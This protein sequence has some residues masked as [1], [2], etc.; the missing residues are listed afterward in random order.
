MVKIPIIQDA[1]TDQNKS[2]FKLDRLGLFATDDQYNFSKLNL[3]ANEKEA[4]DN[5]FD[6]CLINGMEPIAALGSSTDVNVVLIN[7]L[8]QEIKD[9]EK[10]RCVVT[11]IGE[12][13]G[14]K[15]EFQDEAFDEYDGKGLTT[16]KKAKMDLKARQI[17]AEIKQQVGFRTELNSSSWRA[18]PLSKYKA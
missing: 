9:V 4:L 7:K 1:A 14:E 17:E 11:K 2:K 8:G 12:I 16:Q 13:A 18:D 6:I 15:P 10:S 3:F 5:F